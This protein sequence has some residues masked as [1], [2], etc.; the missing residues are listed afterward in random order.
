MN[1]K[2]LTPEPQAVAGP[3]GEANK[4][5]RSSS[6]NSSNSS[7]TSSSSSDNKR[8]WSCRHKHKKSKRGKHSKQLMDKLFKEME[9]RKASVKELQKTIGLLNF[10]SFVVP[11]GRL[12][13]RQMLMFLN[14]LP[15]T[16][17]K[18]YHLPENVIKELE[19]WKANC[20]LSTPLHYPPPIHFLATDASD[21]AWGA[22]LKDLAIW[23]SWSQE[24]QRL[25]SNQ[26]E[27][28]AILHALQTH[29][30]LMKH[31][32]LL[33]QCDNK[34]AVAQLRKEGGTKSISLMNITYQILKLLD[35]HKIHFSIHYIPGK[36]NNHAD[37]LSRHRQPPE[38]HILPTCA[39]MVFAKWG[40][41]VID[42]FA[43]KTAHVVYNYVSRDLNDHQA[44]FH[45]AFSVPWNY[46]LAWVFPPPFLIPKV[47]AH[48]NQ[49]TGIFLIVVP[50]WERVFWRADLKA[51]S[52]EAPFTL[53]NSHN[54]L[55]DTS[56]GLPP[57]KVESLTL[58]V[59]RCGG[60]LKL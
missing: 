33:I 12:H 7:S 34:T 47:L 60:G 19:W 56:T 17:Q 50:R 43:S 49:S 59:W 52:L 3:S 13:H 11:R 26:K 21:L 15:K 23:G 37:H 29:V 45:D 46:P 39:E 2:T 30:H 24:E 6:S 55:I 1:E 44:L 58:E 22:Q 54:R 53:N 48:L 9:Q 8:R 4:R 51:R 18:A 25:H 57:Q 31:S 41:P 28:L 40:T 27:M 38:W 20:Q 10:A 5:R 42:L 36:Y 35:H 16:S 32:S 14:S